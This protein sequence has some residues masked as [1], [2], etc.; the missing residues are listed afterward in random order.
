M[1]IKDT[2]EWLSNGAK[3]R[4]IISITNNRKEIFEVGEIVQLDLI[5]DVL[6]DL[7]H[8]IQLRSLNDASKKL[9][10]SCPLLSGGW[11]EVVTDSTDTPTE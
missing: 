2:A 10:V 7:G 8:G 3:F 5:S 6:A 9:Y 11:F 4:V 1:N